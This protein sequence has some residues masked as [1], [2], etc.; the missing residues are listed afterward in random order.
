[1]RRGGGTAAPRLCPP[2]EQARRGWAAG[3]GAGGLRAPWARAQACA[4]VR[5]W[6]GEAVEL[7]RPRMSGGWVREPAASVHIGAQTGASSDGDDRRIGMVRGWV[8]LGAPSWR[9]RCGAM[10]LKRSGARWGDRV[11]AGGASGIGACGR[12]VA[13]TP[14]HARRVQFVGA[15]FRM[16]GKGANRA[17]LCEQRGGWSSGTVVWQLGCSRLG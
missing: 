4:C 14:P 2:G 13:Y 16:R 9:A 15:D 10:A 11:T 1:V 12:R 3:A 5:T 17:V 6:R 8:T 7:R